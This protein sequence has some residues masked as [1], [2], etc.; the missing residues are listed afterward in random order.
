[1]V[2]R[3][4]PRVGGVFVPAFVLSRST[5]IVD[6]ESA[7]VSMGVSMIGGFALQSRTGCGVPATRQGMIVRLESHVGRHPE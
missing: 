6:M 2:R 1:M 3:R 4:M 7:A 5:L